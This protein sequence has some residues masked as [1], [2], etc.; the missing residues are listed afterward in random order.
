MK[1]IIK[2]TLTI[3]IALLTSLAANSQPGFDDGDNVV[4][5]QTVPINNFNWVM[6][7]VAIGLVLILHYKTKSK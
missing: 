5:V 1:S 3:A 4:D 7:L 2:N 6:I